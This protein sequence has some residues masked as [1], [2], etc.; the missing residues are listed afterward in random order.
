MVF[1]PVWCSVFSVRHDVVGSDNG[2]TRSD[3]NIWRPPWGRVGIPH[4]RHKEPMSNEGHLKRTST[5]IVQPFA[6]GY[7]NPTT[8]SP[9]RSASTLGRP[10]ST[11]FGICHPAIWPPR[12]LAKF[13][14]QH[15]TVRPQPLGRSSK[16]TRSSDINHPAIWPP[17]CPV[18]RPLLFGLL[19]PQHLGIRP[20]GLTRTRP[21][22]H[23]GTRPSGL[24]RPSFKASR[25]Q[26]FNN[27]AE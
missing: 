9:D 23:T 15:S 24:N 21:F 20:F 1:N 6:L 11:K 7:I 5:S 13:G 19:W 18:T 17:R 10:A 2:P 4:C 8:Q 12:Y 22:G 27:S 25:V 14:I 26:A 16:V 3:R